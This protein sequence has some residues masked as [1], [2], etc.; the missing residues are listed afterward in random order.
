MRKHRD[1]LLEQSEET[2]MKVHNLEEENKKLKEENENL[3]NMLGESYSKHD[4][5]DLKAKLEAERRRSDALAD[6]CDNHNVDT[7][8]LE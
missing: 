6:A 8:F 3:E 4:I 1:T 2:F 7:S 5:A